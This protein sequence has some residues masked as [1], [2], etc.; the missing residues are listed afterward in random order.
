MRESLSDKWRN[1]RLNRLFKLRH[2]LCDNAERDSIPTLFREVSDVGLG[3][4][5]WY[6]ISTVGDNCINGVVLMRNQANKVLKRC[7]YCG[8]AATRLER[9]HVVPRCLYP[10]SKR[11]SKV[12]LLTVSACTS[13]NRSWSD[14]EAHFRN[15]L[16]I[17]GEPSVAV[18]ELWDIKAWPSFGKSD[19][20]RR[21]RDLAETNET[22]H[23][24]WQ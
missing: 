14:D 21:L 17:A 23:S 5:H 24:R 10:A 1:E 7:A 22:S 9:E 2:Y 19:G 18:R 4:T 3:Y 12:Q 11:T 13:C 6:R 15:V 20:E 16:L 8:K